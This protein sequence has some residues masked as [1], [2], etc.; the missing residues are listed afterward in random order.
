MRGAEGVVD[1][2]IRQRG[3]LFRVFR[4]IFGFRL[5]EADVFDHHDLAGL[6][7]LGHGVGFV[8]HDIGGELHFPAHQLGQAFRHRRQGGLLFGFLVIL[9]GTAEMGTENNRRAVIRQ[10]PDGG[11]GLPDA[12]VVGDYTVGQRYVEVAAHQ[13]L[14]AVDVDVFNGFFVEII[15]TA[16]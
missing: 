6:Q 3:Q 7:R 9:L 2:N 14:F 1:I 11:D 12:L 4:I 8:P 15:H 16:L 10:I 13:H 5:E